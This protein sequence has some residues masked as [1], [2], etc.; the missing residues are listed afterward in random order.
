MK[1]TE[2][3]NRIMNKNFS[4]YKKKLKQFC[5][6]N[7]LTFDDD[8][9]QETY[10]KVYSK[11]E[12]SGIKAKT[13]Q[14]YLDYFF[15]AFKLNTYLNY[16]TNLAKQDDNIDVQGLE[17]LEN[18]PYDESQ[19][20]FDDFSRN[21]LENVVKEKF[22]IVTYRV[23]RIR[24]LVTINGK[25]LNYKQVKEI[26]GVKD[27]RRRIVMVNKFLRDNFERKDLIIAYNQ[28][29]ENMENN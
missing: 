4:Q 11:I 10:V 14:E 24:Y 3:F 15:K 16:K 8:V 26:T 9:L 18:E 5:F 13:E 25:D 7:G 21:Y 1:Q 29:L 19:L 27:T 22:D 23:W 2:E 20:R 17:L 28:F 6:L 12:R